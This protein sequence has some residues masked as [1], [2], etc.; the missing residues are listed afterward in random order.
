MTGTLSS[1]T[2]FI[3]VVKNIDKNTSQ[4]DQETHQAMEVDE[5]AS[6]SISET[7]SDN[8]DNTQ[9][10]HDVSFEFHTSLHDQM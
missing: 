6:E 8:F 7:P 10:S 1:F 5:S 3:G 4:P 2:A 9:T